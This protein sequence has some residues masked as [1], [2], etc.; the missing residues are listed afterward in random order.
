MSAKAVVSSALEGRGGYAGVPDS[1]KFAAADYVSSSGHGYGRKSDHLYT[2]K[3]SDYN[4]IDRRQYAE[5]HSAYV[6]RELA[7][8]VAGRY[9]DS[10]GYGHQRQVFCFLYLDHFSN[11]LL[12]CMV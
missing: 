6:G 10:V 1:P 11:F 5:H 8:E 4:T 9:I 12:V 3:I 2:E 7:T